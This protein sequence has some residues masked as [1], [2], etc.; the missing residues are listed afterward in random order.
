[1]SELNDLKE[2]LARDNYV[3]LDTETTGLDADSEIVQIAVVDRD[4]TTLLNTL[5]KPTRPI[6]SGATAIHGITNDMVASAP[7]FIDLVYTV[8]NAVHGRDLII[9]NSNYD[10]QMLIQTFAAHGNQ[11]A[12]ED[13]RE[14][15]NSA[16]CAMLAYAEFYGDWNDY[17]QSYR[18]QRLSSACQQQRIKVVDAHN[19]L[20]DCKMTLALIQHLK[21]VWDEQ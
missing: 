12:W 2:V 19:A 11:D 9:Y 3:I 15:V 4:G 21:K 20:G 16:T 17:R 13:F 1:M 14:R 10:L 6:P 8:S 7:P 18:W 5:V